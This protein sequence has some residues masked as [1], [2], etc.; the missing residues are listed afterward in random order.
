MRARI[1]LIVVLIVLII[2]IVV[3]S[4]MLIPGGAGPGDAS[5]MADPSTV[6]ATRH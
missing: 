5:L 3:P 2:V 4:G 6:I 1:C